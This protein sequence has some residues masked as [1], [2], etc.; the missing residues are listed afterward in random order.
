MPGRVIKRLR[1]PL[2]TDPPMDMG[3]HEMY[4]RS[5]TCDAPKV[6]RC[7]VCNHS[8]RYPVREKTPGQLETH[9]PD[10]LLGM[11]SGRILETMANILQVLIAQRRTIQRILRGALNIELALTRSWA[12]TAVSSLPHL[13]LC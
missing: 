7:L 5:I 12:H 11:V 4:R 6:E 10:H 8:S 9:M 2:N 1:L 13:Q 3:L